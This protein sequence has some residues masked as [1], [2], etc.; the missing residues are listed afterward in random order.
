MEGSHC[1]KPATGC[2]TAGK[3]L[4]VAEYSHGANDSIGCAIIG[5]FVYRGTA[6]AALV[7]RY[8][9]GDNCSGKIWDIAAAGPA[10]Q[11]PQLLLSSGVNIT[12]WGQGADGELYLVASNGSLYHLV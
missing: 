1:Y 11:S 8:F 6:N 4:P 9:F 2:S 3:V 12:G 10:S 7:G 5:G